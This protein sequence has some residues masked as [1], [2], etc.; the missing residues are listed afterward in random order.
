MN[1]KIIKDMFDK[2]INK[3]D[4]YNNV[5]KKKKINYWKYSLIPVSIIV[6]IC[7]I[8]LNDNKEILIKN[9]SDI[10]YINDIDIG[11]DSIYDIAW[12]GIIVT[13]EDLSLK[14]SWINELNNSALNY[15]S[16]IDLSDDSIETYL[17]LLSYNDINL[18][19][20]MSE[21]GDRKPRCVSFLDEKNIKES[22]ISG[23]TTKIYKS[24]NTYMAFFNIAGF[25]YDIEI[26]NASE[27][28][29]IKLIKLII[30]ENN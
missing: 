4:I 11:N 20:F 12:N 24:G 16:Y 17:M 25:N 13:K 18:E 30:N 1:K 21:V 14:F 3:N 26:S 8:S 29:F 6:L 27:E 10:I 23:V 7:F 2:N 22:I 5:L 15:S 28:E 9:N 19:I